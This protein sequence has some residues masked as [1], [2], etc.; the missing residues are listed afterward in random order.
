MVALKTIEAALAFDMELGFTGTR[1]P[2]EAT[3]AQLALMQGD[4]HTASHWAT[5]FDRQLLLSFM[6]YNTSPHLMLPR[7]LIAQ[8]T[9]ASLGEAA[10]LLPKMRQFARG[11]CSTLDVVE[12][13]PEG[14][15][16]VH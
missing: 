4:L 14:R 11:I 2:I 12:L 8:R 5:A 10:E 13:L 3:R 1:L 15:V 7:I 9:D 6:T 16:G